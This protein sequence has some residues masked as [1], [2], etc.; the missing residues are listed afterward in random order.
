LSGGIDSAVTAYKL[1]RKGWHIE[2]FFLDILPSG[3]QSSSLAAAKNIARHLGIKFHC[4][5]ESER[6]EDEVI[7]YFSNSYNRGLTPNPCVVCNNRIKVAIGLSLA[8]T[9]AINYLATGH[10]S[11]TKIL[12]SGHTG[13]KRAKDLKKDQSYFLHQ[14]PKENLPR[15]LFPLGDYTK[16]EV[17]KIACK[18]GLFS[19]VQ[20]E[21]Q[22]IC[23]LKG[24]YRTFLEKR[25]LLVNRPGDI[26]T[27]DG[28]I[29]GRHKGLY[30]YTIGQR[31]GIGIPDKTPYYVVALDKNTNQLV[32]G[33]EHNLWGKEFIVEH[34]NWLVPPNIAFRQ[35]CTVKIR[36]RHPGGL[37]NLNFMESD[38][39]RVC[40]FSDQWAITPGQFAVFY[41]NDLVL[42]G[43]SICG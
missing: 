36:Y 22:E 39:V 5:C 9:L 14:I 37:A 7:S 17:I 10:Y 12:S 24:N 28:K 20:K 2:A 32:I 1:I 23:F 35:P 27:V 8:N 33:K 25:G 21:S 11:K 30:A 34:I 13:L 6:F 38:K 29:L 16:E 26:V 3:I 19:L 42:G 41:L 43:G 40:F 15:I 18:T 31:Q 4:L